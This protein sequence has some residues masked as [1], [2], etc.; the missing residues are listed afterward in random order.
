[1]ACGAADGRRRKGQVTMNPTT[2]ELIRKTPG[3]LGGDACIGRRCIAVWMLVRARRLGVPEDQLLDD[4]EPPLT[5][6][7]LD[8]ARH[9]YETHRDEIE[10]AIRE[11]EEAE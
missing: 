1:M 7:E 10:T 5:R 8:A 2:H 6:A 4:H 3:V 11:N 9:Y